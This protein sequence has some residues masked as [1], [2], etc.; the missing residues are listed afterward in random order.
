MADGMKDKDDGAPCVKV[1]VIV[2]V[3][4][5]ERY[6]GECLESIRAQAY[7]DIEVMMIDDGSTD[8]SADICAGFEREDSRFRLV[9]CA[10]GG[11]SRARNTGIEMARGEYLAF[12]DADDMMHEDYLRLLVKGVERTGS[13][14]CVCA[15]RYA[16]RPSYSDPPKEEYRDYDPVELTRI[17]MY[18]KLY[19]N[20][21]WGMLVRRSVFGDGIRFVEGIRYED[22]DFFYRL[23]LSCRKV[24]YLSDSLYFYR[25]HGGSFMRRFTPDRLDVL[26]VTDNMLAYVIENKPELERAAR[27]RRFSA[28]FNMLVLMLANGGGYPDAERRCLSVIKEERVRELTDP[29]VRLKNK[30]G[31]FAS[32]GGRPLIRLLCRMF[33]GV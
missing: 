22:L 30:L 13:D 33:P 26:D 21:A 24:T 32:F 11:V 9:K 1:S 19:V 18:Q 5:A 27:D 6:L 17:G 16:E 10:N 3:Y 20:S 4:N 14:M 8:I 15:F 2:P 23:M 28:H 25:K 12:I 29:R 31:A 7:R